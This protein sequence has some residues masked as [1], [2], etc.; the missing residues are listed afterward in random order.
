VHAA[1]RMVLS[2]GV[3]GN[4]LADAIR[5]YVPAVSSIGD[6]FRVGRIAHAVHSAYKTAREL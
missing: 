3:R 4:N 5:P 6:A 2:V 1:S